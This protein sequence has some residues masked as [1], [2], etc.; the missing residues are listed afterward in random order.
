MGWVKNVGPLALATTNE[1]NKLISPHVLCEV[2]YTGA[3]NHILCIAAGSK[4]DGATHSEIT[5]VD[6]NTITRF[7]ASGS[8][9]QLIQINGLTPGTYITLKEISGSSTTAPTLSY[10]SG[11][12]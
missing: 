5:D 1:N 7:T 9:V 10:I 2:T 8:G 11:K 6:G 3:T 4:V 12:V